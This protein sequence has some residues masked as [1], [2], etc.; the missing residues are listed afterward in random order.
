[1]A[2]ETVA[3]KSA[4]LVAS[5][6]NY[7]GW[8]ATIDGRPAEI[9]TADYLLRGVIVPEGRHRVEMRYTAPAARHGAIITTFTLLA[10]G[11]MVIFGRHNTVRLQNQ[12]ISND[13]IIPQT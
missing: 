1:L 6:V 9:L 4:V 10:L 2:I 8:E 13:E 3:D 7:P 5:E 12:L 11:G